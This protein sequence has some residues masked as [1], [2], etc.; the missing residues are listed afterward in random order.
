VIGRPSLDLELTTQDIIGS[1]LSL[2]QLVV[3]SVFVAHDPSGIIGNPAKLALAGISLAFDATVITQK[4]WLY[5]GQTI[6]PRRTVDE[7][8]ASDDS[9]DE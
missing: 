5:S 7:S 9:D 2:A 8:D 3:S 4:C 6:L 1:F